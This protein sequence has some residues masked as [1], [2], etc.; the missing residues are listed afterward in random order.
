MPIFHIETPN[1]FLFFSG[2]DRESVIKYV[3]NKNLKI[4]AINK[5][6]QD[7]YNTL[8]EIKFIKPAEEIK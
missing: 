2:S 8:L 5:V 7:L 3:R 1:D 6:D 4:N